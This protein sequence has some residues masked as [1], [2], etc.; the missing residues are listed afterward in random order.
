MSSPCKIA[1]LGNPNCGKTTLFNLLTGAKQRTGNWSGVTVDRKEGSFHV[2]EQPVTVVDLPGTYSLSSVTAKGGIDERIACQYILS[3]DAD[4]IVNIIDAANLERNLYLTMQLLEMK[5]P[6][7]VALNMVDSAKKKNIHIDA[8]KLSQLLGCPVIPMITTRKKGIQELKQAAV[9]QFTS[10]K[11]SDFNVDYSRNIESF[12]EELCNQIT[13]HAPNIKRANWLS[14][15]LMENDLLSRDLVLEADQS[16]QLEEFLSQT[17]RNLDDMDLEIADARY[18]AIS[19]LYQQVVENRVATKDKLTHVIDSIVLN[20]YLGLPIFLF[21]MYLMFVVSINIGGGLQPIFDEGSAAIFIDGTT[22]LGHFIG[23]PAWLTAILAQGIGGGINTILPFVPQ[24]G[25]MFLY[26]SLLE[27]SGYMARAAFV[28]DRFMQAIGLPGKSFVPLIVGFGCNIPTVMATRTLDTPRDRIMTSMMAPFM[29]CGARLAIFG[30]FAA[31]FFQGVGSF[32]VFSLY[33]LGIVV[34]VLTGL[35]LKKTLLAGEPHP[36]VMEMPVY[37]LPNP[38][39]ALILTWSRLKRFLFK[40]GKIIIPVC[41]IV[42]G[43]NSITFSGQVINP[44]DQQQSALAQIGKTV[45]PIFEPMGVHK[46]NWPATVGLFTG[47]L[48]KEVVVGTLNSLYTAQAASEQPF[49]YKNF[50]LGAELKQALE[51][52]WSGLKDSVS[53]QT[54]INPIKAGQADASMEGSAMGHMR[55][56]FGTSFAAYAYL[57]FV[58][59]YVPCVATVGAIAREV[60]RNWA[61]LS[62]AW[63]LLVAYA[64]AVIFY[65]LVTIMSHPLS[66]VSWIVAMLVLIFAFLY[67]LRRYSKTGVDWELPEVSAS[68]KGCCG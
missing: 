53:I 39:T 9:T 49:D 22:W 63:G 25:L 29:T 14:L 19:R 62:T 5:V 23:L 6:V 16:G 8:D 58:L 34:A 46:D 17:T 60:G 51:D 38:F 65:Q 4:V 21:V 55:L 18:Q 59:L 2:G 42:L 10:P 48:A 36:F 35:I 1:L 45:T 61:N 43:L 13:S 3:E 12:R 56:L 57:I 68:N 47:F 44:G 7:V 26:L 28:I 32:V 64:V 54:W 33:L 24:I 67:G 15:R 30:V 50:D 27:D 52:T 66:S 41:A 37:H 11:T 31:A 40:A 20:K